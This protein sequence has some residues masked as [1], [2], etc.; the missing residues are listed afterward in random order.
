M[1]IKA[2]EPEEK[3]PWDSREYEHIPLW[4][5]NLKL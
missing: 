4:E 5:E 1:I 3:L 2:V